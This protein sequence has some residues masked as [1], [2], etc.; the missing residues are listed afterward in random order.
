MQKSARDG[1]QA[2][3]VD[4][5]EAGIIVAV[6]SN[7]TMVNVAVGMI[8]GGATGAQETSNIKMKK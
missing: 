2:S 7:G 4:V 1:L 8:S 3:G 6:G 5:G